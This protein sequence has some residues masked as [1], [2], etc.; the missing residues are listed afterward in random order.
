LQTECDNKRCFVVASSSTNQIVGEICIP[1]RNMDM[2]TVS[3]YLRVYL[4][5]VPNS[6]Y[7]N[8]CRLGRDDIICQ[9]YIPIY[10]IVQKVW[11]IKYEE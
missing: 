8:T 1:L 3:L 11:D 9:Y 10:I 7:T 5:A 2:L 6:C 4:N